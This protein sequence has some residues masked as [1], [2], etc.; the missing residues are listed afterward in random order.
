MFKIV[1]K[2][3]TCFKKWKLPKFRNI[4]HPSDGEH[5]LYPPKISLGRKEQRHSTFCLPTLFLVRGDFCH[6]L[7]VTSGGDDGILIL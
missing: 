3:K 7:T 4:L 2:S 6:I 5:V 1:T